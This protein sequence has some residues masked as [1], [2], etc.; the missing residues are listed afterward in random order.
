MRYQS[1]PSVLLNRKTALILG[2]GAIGQY[3]GKVLKSMEMRVLGVKRNPQKKKDAVAEIYPLPDLH[4][5]LPQADVLIIALPL[6]P[7]TNNLIGDAELSLL[8]NGALLVNVGRGPIVDQAALY[9]SL[10]GGHLS[11]AGID[12]W[13][14]YPSDPESHVNTPPADYPFHELDNVV[15]SPHRGG[16]SEDSDTLRMIHLTEM[17]NMALQGEP[18][19]NQV[20]LQLGY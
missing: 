4:E 8:P 9:T 3:V 1:N 5:L 19:P 12:V 18:L 14:N 7:E 15:M 17:L 10:N 2:Y 16:G 11:G 13:Y 20:N 6:T